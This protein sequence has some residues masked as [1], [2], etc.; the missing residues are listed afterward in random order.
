MA[1]TYSTQ[2]TNDRATPQVTNE[3]N[4]VKRRVPFSYTI[5]GAQTTAS[6]DYE[7]VR[8][9]AGCRVLLTESY[10]R[11]SAD[12]TGDMHVGYAAY[13]KHDGTTETAD[14]DGIISQ[15][16]GSSTSL[17]LLSSA[18]LGAAAN[19]D[20]NYG[21]VDFSDAV[22]DVVI[23]GKPTDNGGTYDGDIGD[24]IEGWF[25]VEVH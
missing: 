14:P 11:F 17:Q 9:P 16:G 25:T 20:G 10:I 6:D 12:Q 2:R 15:L 21:V 8:V 18:T 3:G 4:W 5:A 1:T 19:D 7:F 22:E 13:K 24:V 23:T